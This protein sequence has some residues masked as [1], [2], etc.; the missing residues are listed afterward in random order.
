M[1]ARVPQSRDRAERDADFLRG[2][3]HSAISS[4]PCSPGFAKATQGKREQGYIGRGLFF[5]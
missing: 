3:K 5:G 2:L 4:R 1:V